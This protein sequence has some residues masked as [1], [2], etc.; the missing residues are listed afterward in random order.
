MIIYDIEI[1]KLIPPKTGERLPDFAYCEGWTDYVGM[2]LACAVIYDAARQEYHVFD[3]FDLDKLK[4]RLDRADIIC[5]F[6]NLNFDNNVL[7][8]YDISIPRHKNYDILL[9]V[10][11][12]AGTPDNYSGLSLDAIASANL[13]LK[14]SGN[15]ADAPKWYQSGSYG[16][17]FNY[18]LADVRLTKQ[19]LDRIIETG[20]L[21]NP[22]NNKWIR[23]RRP[24]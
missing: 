12:A 20:H 15:G 7:A 13:N 21:I 8:A 17:L 18:C 6:N 14:K 5:G 3:E 24:Q 16:K 4:N 19:I 2:G 11:K 1:Q 23:V 10:A 22:R 9:E